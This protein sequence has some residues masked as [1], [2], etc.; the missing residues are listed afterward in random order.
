[1]KN[2]IK[3]ADPWNTM[4]DKTEYPDVF[5]YNQ[6]L[7]MY[8]VIWEMAECRLISLKWFEKSISS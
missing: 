2:I 8:L 7:D 1:M 5:Q 3:Q 6:W 4:R